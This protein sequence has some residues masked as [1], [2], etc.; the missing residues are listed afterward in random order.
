MYFLKNFILSIIFVLLAAVNDINCASATNH[1]VSDVLYCDIKGEAALVQNIYEKTGMQYQHGSASIVKFKKE[2]NQVVY[3]PVQHTADYIENPTSKIFQCIK[4]V[5]DSF[6]PNVMIL[7]GFE[8]SEYA[9]GWMHQNA[10]NIDPRVLYEEPIYA[11]YLAHMKNIPFISGEPLHQEILNGVQEKGYTLKDLF[12]F[13]FLQTVPQYKRKGKYTECELPDVFYKISR[14]HNFFNRQYTYE[15]FQTWCINK[16]GKTL[17]LEEILESTK[18]HV[19]TPRTFVNNLSREAM[20]IRDKKIAQR[21]LEATEN[22]DKVLI[23][24]GSSHYYTQHKFLARNFGEPVSY[25]L[26]EAPL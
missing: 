8:N 20:F 11:T 14:M 1:D 6:Q 16:L 19:N 5:V 4:H 24:Y 12:F 9:L 25:E 21:I 7:E 15:E 10:K 23:I 26:F 18:T 3:I 13:Y 2:N 22:H 17:T